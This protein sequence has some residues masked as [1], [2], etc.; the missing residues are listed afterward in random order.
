MYKWNNTRAWSEAD[1]QL[2]IELAQR[3]LSKARISVQLRRPEKGVKRRAAALGIKVKPVARLPAT[4]R[5]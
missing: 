1:D 5:R 3:G 4:D 2:L